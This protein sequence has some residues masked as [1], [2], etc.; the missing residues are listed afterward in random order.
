MLLFSVDL[1]LIGDGTLMML[2]GPVSHRHRA[3]AAVHEVGP[4]SKSFGT[5]Y[6][7]LKMISTLRLQ[8]WNLYRCR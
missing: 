1:L 8:D 2:I 6:D 4:K 7:T 5:T 3:I